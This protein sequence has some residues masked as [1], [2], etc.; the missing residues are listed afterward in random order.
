MSMKRIRDYYRKQRLAVLLRL[1]L[2][3]VFLVAG[4]GKLPHSA[5]FSAIVAGYG[6]LPDSLAHIYALLLPWTEIIVGAMLILGILPRLTSLISLAIIASFITAN[7]HILISGTAGMCGC[8]G[9]IIPLTHT[10]SLAT[11]FLMIAAAM[12][13]L[14]RPSFRSAM[15]SAFRIMVKS[16]SIAVVF[17]VAV[18]LT[19]SVPAPAL[20]ANYIP[21]EIP[22]SVET[23]ANVIAVDHT[24][25][26]DGTKDNVKPTLLFFYNDECPGC[27]L[28]KPIIDALED[29]Y[30][31]DINIERVNSHDDLQLFRDYG[32]TTVPAMVIIDGGQPEDNNSYEIL[33]GYTDEDTILTG[34]Y[35]PS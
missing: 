19:I 6:L 10:Q 31:D 17:L 12:F 14:F 20:A 1:I 3:S 25:T 8:F 24:V 9:E 21:A 35:C 22:A 29:E 13:L 5:E 16:R 28:Q 27:R 4:A 34:C 2:G 7:V 23:G 11:N 33:R 18:M 30:R 15:R 32:I 26:N